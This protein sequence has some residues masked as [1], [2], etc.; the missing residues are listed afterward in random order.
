MTWIETFV[1]EKGFDTEMTFEVK[2]GDDLHLV[3]L[4]SVIQGIKNTTKEERKQIKKNL[5]RMD[6]S[7]NTKA[8]M[9]YF[10][11]LAEGLVKRESQNV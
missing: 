7:N 11:Q 2:D 3:S 10:H 5:I 6:F 9:D 1:E 4:G 8:M